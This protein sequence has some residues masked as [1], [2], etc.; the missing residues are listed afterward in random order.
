MEKKINTMQGK[1]IELPYVNSNFS[2]LVLLPKLKDELNEVLEQIR[3]K[4]NS[5]LQDAISKLELK[6]VN[7]SLPTIDTTTTTDLKDILQKVN[8]SAIFDPSTA[9]QNGISHDPT[10]NSSVISALQKAAVMVNES[11]SEAAA[12][13]G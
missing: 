13:N 3:N 4:T 5:V 7:I 1:V 11:G 2:Y 6:R 10:V 12:R 9:N 8:I